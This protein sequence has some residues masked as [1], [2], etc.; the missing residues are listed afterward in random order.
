MSSFDTSLHFNWLPRVSV[1]QELQNWRDQQANASV[2]ADTTS[3]LISK[4]SG[5][6]TNQVEGSAKLAAQAA[7][8]RVNAAVK[9][10]Q[11]A[12]ANAS[13]SKATK[14]SAPTSVKLSTGESIPIDPALTLAGG[15]KVNL[16]DGTLT[17][18]DG[19]VIDIKT[20]LKKAVDVT[21]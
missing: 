14:P 20:G 13:S 11:N 2:A 6:A 19:T 5:A 3:A 10:K 15:S 21:V 7:L 1:W 4:M 9:V 12:R 17:L 16:N 18:S 8:D